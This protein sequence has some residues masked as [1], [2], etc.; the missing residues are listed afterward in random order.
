M[1]VDPSYGSVNRQFSCCGSQ[2]F[3]CC[4]CFKSGCRSSGLRIR[5]ENLLISKSGLRMLGFGFP[6]EERIA[7]L[8]EMTQKQV[9]ERRFYVAIHS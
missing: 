2:E 7:A 6:K 3:L 4:E 9:I 5:G 8:L 1:R